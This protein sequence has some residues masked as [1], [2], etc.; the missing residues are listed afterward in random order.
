[1]SNIENE[2]Y[3]NEEINENKE[4]NKEEIKENKE[5]KKEEKNENEE[6]KNIQS[7]IN[8]T[9]I[10]NELLSQIKELKIKTDEKFEEQK[11]KL[12][13]SLKEI[14]LKFDNLDT[15]NKNITESLA[16]INV[17]LDIIKELEVFKKKTENQIITHEIRINNTMKDLS[18]AKFK[19]DKIYIDNLSVPGF[20]GR[21]AQYKTMGEYIYSNIITVSGINTLTTQMKKDL[22]ELK[23]N[24]DNMTKGVVTIVNSASQRCNDY[25]DNKNKM[26]EN[27]IKLEIKTNSEKIMDVRMQNVKA[28]MLLEKKAKEL[29]SEWNKVGDIRKDIEKKLED[30]IL[31]YKN[32][33]KETFDKYEKMKIEF[34]KIKYRFGSL[35][36]FI[37]DVR[38]RKNLGT[39]KEMKKRDIKKLTDKLKFRKRADSIDSN[40]L[41]KLDINYDFLIGKSV[42]SEGEDED[43]EKKKRVMKLVKKI[44]SNRIVFDDFNNNLITIDK[45]NKQIIIDN[46]EN[47]KQIVIDSNNTND[48]NNNDENNNAEI[49][50]EKDNMK[51]IIIE[52]D[53]NNN[54]NNNNNKDNKNNN[55]KS[56]DNNIDNKIDNNNKNKDN[57]NIDNNKNSNDNN[58]DNN[59]KNKDSSNIDNNNKNKDNSNID[60][61]NKNKDNINNENN[62][63]SSDNNIDNNNKN[64]DNIINNN[65]SKIKDNTNNDNN[66]KNKDKIN[67]DNN[68]KSKDKINNDNNEK[69]NINNNNKETSNTTIIK[70]KTTKNPRRSVNINLKNDTINIKDEVVKEKENKLSAFASPFENRRRNEIKS[71]TIN[72]IGKNN[73]RYYIYSHNKTESKEPNEER[74]SFY[75]NTSNNKSSYKN[76][77]NLNMNQDQNQFNQTDNLFYEKYKNN[78]TNFPNN[79]QIISQSIN[80]NTLNN[81]RFNGK[82]NNKNKVNN[83]HSQEKMKKKYFILN[84]PKDYD[85][86]FNFNFIQLGIG[87][88]PSCNLSERDIRNN[89]NDSDNKISYQNNKN[90]NFYRTFSPSDYHK[91]HIDNIETEVYKRN[92]LFN[93]GYVSAQRKNY[94]TKHGK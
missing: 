40:D 50:I 3:N 55:I 37:K 34:N 22:M 5:N 46:A 76:I 64:N 18:D 89:L 80:N 53:E 39:F 65:S 8:L 11:D 35:V 28:A 52:E 31:I 93:E 81:I 24:I 79:N 16:D 63:N 49:I 57:N 88:H 78:T 4:K 20:I 44:S 41:D 27:D 73:E 26:L 59:N 90:T 74:N 1:M 7:P 61:N 51:K 48:N 85:P 70:I 30:T 15:I 66:S 14:N 72:Q 91:E 17:K 36:E 75:Y 92:V 10:R 38:F 43:S 67:N 87:N 33:N 9:T 45:K 83:N 13:S 94:L 82:N 6:E 32:E 86:N 23:S 77:N 29:E 54:N 60:N 25:S 42:N 68:S 62:K 58:I 47:K 71:K 69:N 21:K 19:Y 56:S 2:E 12:E 84:T